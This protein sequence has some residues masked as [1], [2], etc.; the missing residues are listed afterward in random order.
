MWVG[1]TPW[2]LRVCTIVF[3][4]LG[5]LNLEFLRPAFSERPFARSASGLHMVYCNF[6]AVRSTFQCKYL[7][8]CNWVFL[9]TIRGKHF[10]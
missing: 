9:T 4:A 5:F 8:H 7:V 2:T 10:R 6:H 3:R 1:G